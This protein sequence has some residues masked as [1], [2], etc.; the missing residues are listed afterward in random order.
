MGVS[1]PWPTCQ[2]VLLAWNGLSMQTLPNWKSHWPLTNAV[3]S[4]SMSRWWLVWK[5]RHPSSYSA[6][7][8]RKSLPHL[9]T[10][11]KSS[12]WPLQ[13]VHPIAGSSF[14]CVLTCRQGP[15]PP[16]PR[17]PRGIQGFAPNNTGVRK[18]SISFIQTESPSGDWWIGF[19]SSYKHRQCVT[20][21]IYHFVDSRLYTQRSMVFPDVRVGP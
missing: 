8:G 19:K 9:T 12:P 18:A 10:T 15:L 3:I 6:W 5:K 13:K 2:I 21:Q 16:L 11:G 17:T 1:P 20:K 14:P 4:D 7:H